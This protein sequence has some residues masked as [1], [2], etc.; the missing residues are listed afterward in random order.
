[1]VTKR[2]V[3]SE[4]KSFEEL[5]ELWRSEGQ[6]VTGAILG[7]VLRSRGAQELCATTQVGEDWGRTLTRQPQLHGRTIESR[8]GEIER[9]SPYL[10][11]RHCRRGYPPFEQA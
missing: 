10:Y 6:A 1:M 5:S 3:E 4:G 7:E 11:C 9:E 2:T 8:H